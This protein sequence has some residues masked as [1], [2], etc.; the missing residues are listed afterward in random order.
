MVLSIAIVVSTDNKDEER[1]LEVGE[2]TTIREGKVTSSAQS[3]G[4]ATEKPLNNLGRYRV[5]QKKRPPL[6]V[7]EF[8][9]FW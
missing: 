2:K 3:I 7:Q 1:E 4:V 6:R 8:P 9:D 5:A